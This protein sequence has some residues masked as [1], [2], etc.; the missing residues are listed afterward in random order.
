MKS[1]DEFK[2]I[3]TEEKSDYD[4]FDMLIRAGLANKAQIAR[5]H[6]IM[7]KMKEDRPVFNNADRMI[8][9]NL[10]NKM[11][12]LISNNKQIF[13]QARRSVREDVGEELIDE[14]LISTSDYKISPSGRKVRAKRFK[15]SDDPT[16]LDDDDKLKEDL[17]LDEQKVTKGTPPFT[18]IL[19]RKAIRQ[20]PGDTRIALYWSEKLK[21]YFS[22]PY[23]EKDG[24]VSGIIQSESVELTE[25]ALDTLNKI[26]SQKQAMPVKFSSGHTKKVDHFTASA[27][28]NVHKNLNDV[29]KKKYADML[30]KSPEHFLKAA[31]FALKQHSK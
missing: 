15:I 10:F 23:E 5:I 13:Q 17:E 9:Q 14:A 4:K 11:V 22:V 8:L 16:S 12:D 20:Y 31:E 29:N 26:V 7:D 27:I 1:L 30:H 25:S 28:T 24:E 19:K 3:I 21:K 6:K 18:L 2:N